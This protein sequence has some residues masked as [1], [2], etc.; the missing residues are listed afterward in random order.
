MKGEEDATITLQGPEE[1]V[2]RLKVRYLGYRVV[3]LEVG[4]AW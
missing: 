3:G 4:G 2:E 1:A